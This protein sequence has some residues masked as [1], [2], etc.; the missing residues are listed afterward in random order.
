MNNTVKKI[1]LIAIVLIS[2]IVIA[3]YITQSKKNTPTVEA[4][5]SQT[6]EKEKAPD[7]EI[8]DV[9]GKKIKLSSLKGK[10]IV[11]N[12]FSTHCP[13]CKAELPDF[14]KVYNEYSDNE[15]VEFVCVSVIG[16]LGEKQ[17]DAKKYFEKNNFSLPLYLDEDQSASNAYN[18]YSIPQTYIIDKDGY[19]VNNHLGMVDED[20]LKSDIEQITK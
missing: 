3:V 4:P 18:V 11:L 6:Q 12:F 20:T 8:T 7:I 14:Q 19:I 9:N 15:N 10:G 1:L 13:P 17:D 16:A 2:I 5:V